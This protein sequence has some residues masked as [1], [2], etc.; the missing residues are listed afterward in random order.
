MKESGVNFLWKRKS[1][2]VDY[3]D[4]IDNA[5]RKRR[6]MNAMNATSCTSKLKIWS[7]YLN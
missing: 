3:E 2:L 5:E 1:D 6:E 7:S 4:K